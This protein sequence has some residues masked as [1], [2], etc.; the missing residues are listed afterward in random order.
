MKC[1]QCHGTKKV[2]VWNKGYIKTN[3]LC[4]ICVKEEDICKSCNGTGSQTLLDGGG[5]P[6]DKCGCTGLKKE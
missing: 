4:G 6:C 5:W 2:T 1:P 3:T